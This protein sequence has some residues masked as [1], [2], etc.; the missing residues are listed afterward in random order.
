MIPQ[1][2]GQVWLYR[3]GT[4]VRELMQPHGFKERVTPLENLEHDE[5]NR[6][7]PDEGPEGAEVEL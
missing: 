4:P 2:F 7:Q 6:L 5:V 3:G 1:R